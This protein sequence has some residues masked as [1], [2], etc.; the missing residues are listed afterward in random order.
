MKQY[1]IPANSKKSRLIFGLFRWIDLGVLG[2]GILISLLMLFIVEGDTLV[3]MFIKFF[4]ILLSIF[5]VFPIPYYH[6]VMEFIK[7]MIKYYSSP[8]RYYWRGWCARYDIGDEEK[9]S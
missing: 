1:L 8:R 7:D 2:T 9:Q 4:P 5:L 6:N 3:K